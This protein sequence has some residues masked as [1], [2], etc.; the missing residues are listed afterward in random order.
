MTAETVQALVFYF[1]AGIVLVSG[2]VVVYARRIYHSVFALFFLLLSVA[3]FY[4]MLGADFLAVTQVVVYVGGILALLLFGILLTSRTPLVLGLVSRRT[5]VV[6]TLVGAGVFVLVVVVLFKTPWTDIIQEAETQAKSTV[7]PIGEA[8]LTRYIF[9][10]EF[11]SITL[12]AALV[13][14]AY[15]VRRSDK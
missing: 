11:A 13:G 8:F 9:P 1:L 12:L 5:Y 2:A 4:A 6:A 7:E 15:L 3:G 14:A 10:F